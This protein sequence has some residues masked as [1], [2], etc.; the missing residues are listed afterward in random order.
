MRAPDNPLCRDKKL[1]SPTLVHISFLFLFPSRFFRLGTAGRA[2]AT[3]GTAAATAAGCSLE[4][5]PDMTADI[6]CG[7]QHDKCHNNRCNAHTR[8]QPFCIVQF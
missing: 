1:I 5:A 3:A 4:Q 8:S 2:A 7:C 6:K